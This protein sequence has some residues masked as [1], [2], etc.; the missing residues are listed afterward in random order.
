MLLHDGEQ[1][2]TGDPEEAVLRYFRLNFGSTGDGRPRE[3]DGDVEVVEAWLED[4]AGRRVEDVEQ[5][6]PISF[7]VLIEA[8][9]EVVRPTFGFELLNV[10]GVPVL[11]FGGTLADDREQ[12][13]RMAAGQ[14]ARITASIE[15][16]LVAG[17]YS[18]NC[19]VSRNHAA[20]DLAVHDLRLLDFLVKGTRPDPGMVSVE[21]DLVATVEE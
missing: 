15:N 19:S 16:K 13:D 18:V 20:G 21:T 10:D 8:K 4:E 6:R 2:Y 17:R 5:G 3:A 11:G 7:N 9:R 14:Q 1:L 12:P